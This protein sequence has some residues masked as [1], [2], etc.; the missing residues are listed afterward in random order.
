AFYDS[1]SYDLVGRDFVQLIEKLPESLTFKMGPGL[2]MG[3]DPVFIDDDMDPQMM[4][5]RSASYGLFMHGFDRIGTLWLLAAV[6]SALAAWTLFLL[7]RSAARKAP[8]WSFLAVAGGLALGTSLPFF[9]SFAMPDLFGGVV[10]ASAI[11]LM[12]YA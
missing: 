12:L 4:G 3:D 8:R 9:T 10:A 2:D 6:Q 11:T 1:D 5:A 7:W